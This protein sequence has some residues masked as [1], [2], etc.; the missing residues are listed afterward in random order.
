MGK[1]PTL[2]FDTIKPK[3]QE[4][5][6]KCMCCGR[7][8]SKAT[9]FL[10]APNTPLYRN[11]GGRMP[12]CRGCIDTMFDR[13]KEE[14]GEDEA[15]RRICMK[16]DIYY[17]PHLVEISRDTGKYRSRMAAY[18]SKCSLAGSNGKTYD[19]TLR[20]ENDLAVQSYDDLQDQREDSHFI[21]TKEIVQNWGLNFSPSEYEYLE[22]EFQDWC[23]KHV[24]TGKSKEALIRDL[25][26]LK[27]QQNKAILDNKIDTYAKLT[28]TFQKTLDRANLTPKIE[29]ANDKAAEKPLGVM[30]K[31]FEEHDP[32]PTPREE[33]KDPDRIIHFTS[34][35]VLGHLMKMLGIKN[36]HADLYER[37]MNKYRVSV[38]ELSDAD[39]EE[40]FDNVLNHIAD[41]IDEED[42]FEFH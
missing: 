30:I 27:L 25:C 26:I 29:A 37:E 32:I 24:I 35:Y 10:A 28:D 18:I 39:D 33:W 42:G 7:T 1:L 34:V 4:F 17:S 22:N 8:Y 13:Y 16:F 6:K 21:V 14:F 19:N 3:E 12:V 11:N 31:M 5:N 23:S 36:P 20:E 9:D 15:I 2:S 38:P 40:I 41:K